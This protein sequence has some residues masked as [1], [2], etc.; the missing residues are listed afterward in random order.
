[1]LIKHHPPVDVRFTVK[2]KQDCLARFDVATAD[3]NDAPISVVIWTT[4]PWTLPANYG[5]ALHAKHRYVLVECKK[6]NVHEYLIVAET[7]LLQLV[8]TLGVR[9]ISGIGKCTRQ[10]A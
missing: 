2:D 9:A 4:T 6:E 7:L 8:Q 1:M 10:C 5:V 3:F